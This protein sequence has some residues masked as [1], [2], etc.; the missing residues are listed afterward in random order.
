VDVAAMNDEGA[1]TTDPIE[2]LLDRALSRRPRRRRTWLV[3]AAAVVALAAAGISIALTRGPSANPAADGRWRTMTDAGFTGAVLDAKDP[4][5]LYV[6]VEHGEGTGP[7]SLRDPRAV[8]TAQDATSVTVR[9]QGQMRLPAS[10]PPTGNFGFT[11]SISGYA[12]VGVQLDAPL[13]NRKL[14]DGLD[15]RPQPVLDPDTVPTPASVPSGYTAEP[16]TWEPDFREAALLGLDGRYAAWAALRRYRDGY[17]VLDVRVGRP[18]LFAQPT[19]TVRDHVTVAGRRAVVNGDNGT[20]CVT[21]TESATRAVQVCATAQARPVSGA[22]GEVTQPAA[23][24][25]DEQQLRQV[26]DSLR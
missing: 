13:G 11:C 24:P 5:R 2:P 6:L 10:A 25:L 1:A 16:V 22:S 14:F 20:L 3:V 18:Q 9:V 21:W 8:V 12:Q 15:A 7:C 23:A 4:S 19:D 26:A 17:D